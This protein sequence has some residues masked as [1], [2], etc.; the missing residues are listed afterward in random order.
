MTDGG[1]TCGQFDVTARETASTADIAEASCLP[2]NYHD[3]PMVGLGLLLEQAWVAK[4]TP[5]LTLADAFVSLDRKKE[6][7]WRVKSMAAGYG[8]DRSNLICVGDV[9]MRVNGQSIPGVVC[10]AGGRDACDALVVCQPI[11]RS[12][13][14][15]RCLSSK[16]RKRQHV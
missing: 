2:P 16:N 14:A 7:M 10:G 8:A 13:G 9:L 11:A 1:W 6:K 3:V 5:E 12:L 15:L 4:Q